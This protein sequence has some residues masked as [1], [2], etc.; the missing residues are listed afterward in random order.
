MRLTRALWLIIFF[1]PLGVLADRF[2]YMNIVDPL[3][4]GLMWLHERLPLLFAALA[5]TSAGAAALRYTRI[6]ARLR[7]LELLRSTPPKA[8]RE[9]F[10]APSI[11][12][13]AIELIYIDVARVFCFTVF[14]RRVVLSRGFAE[15]LD[16]DE[17]Q[18]VAQHEALHI[19]RRDPLRALL[20]H[21]VFAALIV[22]GFERL[23][24]L[25]YAR[26][27]RSVDMRVRRKRPS[28]YGHLLDRLHITVCGS[29]A[30]AFRSGV[31]SRQVETG[32]LLASSMA[33]VML[34]IL[35]VLSHAVFVQNLPYLQAHH[36]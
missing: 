5:I 3:Y 4:H 27:E 24:D 17:L 28:E 8:L 13:G 26:R 16:V 21:L 34:L 29:P 25:L 11:A 35:L 9:A 23:E 31:A 1:V 36:C 30:A 19:S 20:W 15:L 18:L 2:C 10:E 22:P 14:G 6:Q 32:L 7:A 33:P 12:A